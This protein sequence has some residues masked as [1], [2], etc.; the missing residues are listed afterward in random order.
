MSKDNSS[1]QKIILQDPVKE[2]TSHFPNGDKHHIAQLEELWNRYLLLKKEQKEIQKLSKQVSR[3]IGEAKK[4]G[5]PLDTLKV[6]MQEF[7]QQTKTLAATIKQTSEEI[8]HFFEL[9]SSETQDNTPSETPPEDRFYPLGQKD[10]NPDSDITISLLSNE[11]DKWNEYVES[12]PAASIYHRV[13]W[14]NLIQNTFGHEPSYYY[15]KNTSGKIL[16]ILPLIRIKSRLFGDFMISMP[17]FN[18]G[19]AIADHP[20]IE[21]K[22]IEVANQN[23]A[24]LGIEHIEYRDDIPRKGLPSRTNKVNMILTLPD[25]EDILW[26]QFSPKIR[27]QIKR[28][29]REKPQ[30]LQ[31]NLELLDDFY[32]VFSRNMRDLGTPV[33][34]KSFFRNI[35]E[36]FPDQSRIVAIRLENRPVAAGFLLGQGD[37]LEI[38]WASTVKEVN[39]LSMNMLLY[40]EILRFSISKKYHYFD[41]GRSSVGSGTFK[42][43]Q[44][45]GAVPKS[46]F[47]HYWL[48][49]GKEMPALNPDNPKYSIIIAAWKRLPVFITK[50]IGPMIVKNLP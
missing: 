28:P 31:G 25:H 40:W 17:Y 18:Y 8:L 27:A 5:E 1:L 4:R 30:I 23:A 13:E 21:E 44:Q 34:G 50:L 39:R 15:A 32:Q 43:K 20:S 45:W 2:Y 33:Y 47:W 36:T 12:N 46:M 19:G 29:Q 48:A 38:P 35:L 42:F 22:L 37:M 14:K 24:T 7:S 9:D 3:K 49:N 11:H 26:K 41:F 6:Q 16:G 10:I